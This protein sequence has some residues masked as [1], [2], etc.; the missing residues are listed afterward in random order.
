MNDYEFALRLQAE[1]RGFQRYSWG[2]FYESRV[3]RSVIAVRARP[4]AV[5]GQ[6]TSVCVRGPGFPVVCK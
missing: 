4:K 6:G 1:V 5:F 2:I 3:P